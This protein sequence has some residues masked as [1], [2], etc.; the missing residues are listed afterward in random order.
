[1]K[2]K[3]RF[4]GL[5]LPFRKQINYKNIAEKALDDKCLY[6]YAFGLF[7]LWLLIVIFCSFKAARPRKAVSRYHCVRHLLVP[8]PGQL[9]TLSSSWGSFFIH[10]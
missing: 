1:M 10:F 7:V 9:I 3:I 6:S 5:L 2:L 4:H 8:L